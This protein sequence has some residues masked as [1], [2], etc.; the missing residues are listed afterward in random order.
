MSGLWQKLVG[1]ACYFS[2]MAID[3][4]PARW[5]KIR[6]SF[7]QW[8]A[9]DLER[10]LISIIAGGR[11]PGRAKPD[12]PLLSQANCHDF[13]ISPEQIIDRIDYELSTYRYLGDAFPVFSM[14]CFGPG[15]IAAFMGATL[16]NSTG[17][18]WFHPPAH[19]PIGEIHLRFDPD[20]V[21]FRR[22]CDIYHAGMQRWQG[23]VL[24]SMTDLG[25]NL[26]IV[27]TFRPGEEL[28]MDLYDEPGEVKRLLREAHEAWHQ[29]YNALNEVLQPINPGYS[30]WARI[31]SDTPSYIL[32]CDFS[33]MIGPEM[34]EEFV[35]PE[36]GSTCRRLDR[37]FYHLDG[38]GQ[39]PH[40]DAILAIPELG[41]VQWVPG[42]GQPD[43]SHWP[44][45]YSKIAAAKKN[46]QVWG[47]FDVLDAVRSQIGTGKGIYSLEW[48]TRPGGEREINAMREKLACYGVE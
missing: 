14:D 7:R 10:P 9:G 29:Y 8:W 13:S 42:A 24:M 3:F 32:Q 22:I 26:D 36:L 45:V 48:G 43:C 41:G 12:V 47:G 18:V 30:D 34:F 23:Q 2:I 6:S 44:E 37:S 33:Y 25:G 38:I 21:W 31:Y 1:L 20:S 35:S 39:L 4:D 5:E 19:K 28:L 46:L 11:D 27:S 15:V 16:D 17:G 40:L